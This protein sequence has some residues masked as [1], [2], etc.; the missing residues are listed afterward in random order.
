VTVITKRAGCHS[1]ILGDCVWHL[2]RI[3]DGEHRCRANLRLAS[4][5][6]KSVSVLRLERRCVFDAS[7][8]ARS[9]NV[10]ATGNHEE[11]RFPRKNV[12]PVNSRAGPLP[13]ATLSV[14]R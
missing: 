12:E 7:G 4:S 9:I 3:D 11:P 13:F 14:E 1:G 6:L 2:R 5:T 10:A 8:A